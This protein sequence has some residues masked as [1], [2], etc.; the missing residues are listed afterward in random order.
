MNVAPASW[1]AVAWT[2]GSTL[3]HDELPIHAVQALEREFDGKLH[4]A[5]KAVGA[6]FAI[7]AEVTRPRVRHQVAGLVQCH[8]IAAVGAGRVV[9]ERVDPVAVLHVVI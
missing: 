6:D 5:G 1:P 4:Y 7:G 8:A 9:F 2:S 3:V